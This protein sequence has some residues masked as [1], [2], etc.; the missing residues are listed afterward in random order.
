M[1]NYHL[2]SNKLVEIYKIIINK[3]Y[4]FN[5]TC[6][7]KYLVIVQLELTD[8]ETNQLNLVYMLIIVNII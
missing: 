1:L 8:K 2:T 4:N 3:L 6:H 5:Y 7:T